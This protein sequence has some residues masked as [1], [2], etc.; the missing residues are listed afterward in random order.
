MDFERLLQQVEEEKKTP[1]VYLRDDDNFQSE[2]SNLITEARIYAGLTQEELS[3]LI[4]TKQPSVARWEAAVSLPSLRSLKKIADALNTYLLPP[5]FGFMDEVK[6]NEKTH[7]TLVSHSVWG[8]GESQLMAEAK[9]LP[10]RQILE[11]LTMN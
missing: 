8:S 11:L 1:S 3:K 7:Y 5:K 6:V 4:K 2:V 10:T 9:T